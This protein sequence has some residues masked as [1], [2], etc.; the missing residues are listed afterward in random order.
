MST[1]YRTD[2]RSAIVTFQPLLGAP[3]QVAMQV[4]P[5]GQV[6]RSTGT[7]RSPELLVDLPRQLLGQLVPEDAPE[8]N[9]PV[10]GVMVHL[11][12]GQ[13]AAIGVFDTPDAATQWWAQPF[14]RLARNSEVLFLVAAPGPPS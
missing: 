12:S 1:T 5:P 2:A 14:N 6:E 8:S 9:V 4:M 3:H 13:A 10:I 11:G 7:F